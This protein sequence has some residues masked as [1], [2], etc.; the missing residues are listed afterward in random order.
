MEFTNF[1]RRPFKVEA[2]RITAEN[3]DQIASA[4]GTIRMKGDE[5]FIV[6]DKRIVPNMPRAYIGWWVTRFN[7]NYRCYSNKIFNEQFI[8]YTPDWDQWFDNDTP[9]EPT[10]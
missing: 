2:V 1:V 9:E 10:A 8:P 3:I 5:K 6:I 7:D 4:I